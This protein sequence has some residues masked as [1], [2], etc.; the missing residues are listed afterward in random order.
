[1]QCTI[2]DSTTSLRGEVERI[3]FASAN[4]C[5]GRFLTKGGAH[6]QF[7]GNIVPKERQPLVFHGRFTTHPKYGRQFEV[8]G[9]EFDQRLDATGLA[10]YLANNPGIKG[11]G[12]V[13][14]RTIADRFGSDFERALVETPERIAEVAHVAL[15]VI[16]DLRERWLETSKTNAAMT[17]L[18]A[19]GLT[20]HQ[21][22]TLVK[23]LGNSAV[24]I[25]QRDPYVIVREIDGFGFKKVDKIARQ[26]GI[27]KDDPSRIR[28]GITFCVDDALDQGDC[29]VE[30]EELLD[31]ANA[32]LIMDCLDSRSR[33]ETELDGLIDRGVLTCY[34]ADCRFLVAKPAI[35]QMEEELSEVFAQGRKSNPHTLNDTG[36]AN[37]S[38]NTKQRQAV[39]AAIGSSISL[40]SGGAG[41][42]KTFTIAAITEVYE[43]NDLK[44]V[45]CAPTGKAAKR[46]E[47]STGRQAQTIHRL[48]GF[49][50]HE[51]A[52]GADN[53]ISADV[54]IV[55]E[56]S[57]IDVPLAWR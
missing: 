30:Y 57:M 51:Y 11:I 9:M 48:L 45:L 54:L 40:I 36:F 10:N 22:I 26:V 38:L 28:A 12:P 39:D 29:W 53:P 27:A 42:G 32:L 18:S 25:I 34:A 50:G 3:F 41:S 44:V 47:E 56:A 49:N 1:M 55:D 16:E 43:A 31:R 46:I 2:P 23:K 52:R 7:A 33:I 15:S 5:A 17:A 14:A 24:G 20:H 6:I 19:Y 8:T 13:K 4:F 21:V 37:A 35:R